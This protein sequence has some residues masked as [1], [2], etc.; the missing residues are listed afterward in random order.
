MATPSR[1][2]DS[3]RQE[4]AGFVEEKDSKDTQSATKK[5]F[6][7]IKNLLWRKYPDKDQDFDEISKEELNT[8]SLFT[9]IPMQGKNGEN[10][11]K[12]V[13]TSI[14]FGLQRYFIPKREKKD[15]TSLSF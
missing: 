12:T 14:R 2:A 10:Y 9:F 5:C 13:L 11:K 7:Y 15:L 3:S 6:V 1:F 8:N 4:I